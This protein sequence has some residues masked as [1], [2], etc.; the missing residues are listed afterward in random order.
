[1]IGIPATAWDMN[2]ARPIGLGAMPVGKCQPRSSVC[3][4]QHFEKMALTSLTRHCT[5]RASG[6]VRTLV[7]AVR[8]RRS[9][10]YI[11]GSN[12]RAL[13]KAT[14]LNADCL[15]MDLEDAVSPDKKEL[16]RNQV[17]AALSKHRADQMAAYGRRELIARVNVLSWSSPWGR[18]GLLQLAEAGGADAILLPKVEH[19]ED[20]ER[21]SELLT[22]AGGSSSSATPIWCMIETPLGVLNADR[23][24]SLSQVHCAS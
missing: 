21:A 1:M 23:L 17:C 13:E 10:L 16:A 18:A 24:A 2:R 12:G 3:C 8:P 14:G 11:P 6:A 7:S 19:V 4:E 15:I 5:W 20:V 22:T 9:V